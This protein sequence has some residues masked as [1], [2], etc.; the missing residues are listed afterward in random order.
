[1]S[2]KS[3]GYSIEDLASRVGVPVRTVRFYIAEGLLPGP[4]SRGKAAHYGESHLLRLQVIRRLVEQRIPLKAIPDYLD[5]LSPVEQ[6]ALLAADDGA[7]AAPELATPG[8]AEAGM[9]QA[10]LDELVQRAR[11]HRQAAS[12]AARPGQFIVTS[13]PTAAPPPKPGEA[14]ERWEIA[15]G[16]ELHMRRELAERHHARIQ[17]LLPRLRSLMDLEEQ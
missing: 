4:E 16:I 1:M 8:N 17:A 13:P 5:R 14:W 6:E 10:I 2:E 3:D 9:S 11:L 12:P 15:P 7:S